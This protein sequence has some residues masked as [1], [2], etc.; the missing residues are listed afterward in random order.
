MVAKIFEGG[1]KMKV[2]ISVLSVAL[3][4]CILSLLVL[5]PNN[6]PEQN[7]ANI[8]ESVTLNLSDS[9]SKQKV[10]E[11]R[12]LNMLNHNFVYGEDFLDLESIVN[13]SSVALIDKADENREFIDEQLLVSYVFDMYGIKIVDLSEYKANYPEKE[14]FV[15]IIP[16]GFTSYTHTSAEIIENE[17][18][19]YTV[20]TSVLVKGHDGEDVPLTAK[21]LFVKNTQSAFGFNIIYSEFT[22]NSLSM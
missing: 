21:T 7:K 20:T 8:V 12:F 4:A 16:Q 10:L 6:Q 14:G 18:G 15:Y 13:L 17:D 11:S 22:D 9:Q 5:K 19:S 2:K 3:I 1:G